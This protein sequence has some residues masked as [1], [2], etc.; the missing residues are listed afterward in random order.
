ML[1]M[2][3]FKLEAVELVVYKLDWSCNWYTSSHVDELDEFELVVLLVDSLVEDVE[4][5]DSEPVEDL[6]LIL[7]LMVK[8]LVTKLAV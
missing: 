4:L 1:V 7:L 8:V 2:L 5:V 6:E 3:V